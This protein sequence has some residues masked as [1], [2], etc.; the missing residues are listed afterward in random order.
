MMK[1]IR[2]EVSLRLQRTEDQERFL[3]GVR[4]LGIATEAK[5]PEKQN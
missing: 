1:N 2:R 3:G 4:A 5:S